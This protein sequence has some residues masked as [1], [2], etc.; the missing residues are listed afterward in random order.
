VTSPAGPSAAPPGL[1]DRLRF[2][3][4]KIPAA[5]DRVEP[6]QWTDLLLDDRPEVGDSISGMLLRVGI[7]ARLLHADPTGT[8]DEVQRRLA[9]GDDRHAVMDAL[10]AELAP[11]FD[12]A[13]DTCVELVR[14]GGVIA[15]PDLER[16][17]HARL[18]LDPADPITDA[19]LRDALERLLLDPLSEV[20]GVP[21]GAVVH[22][23]TLLRGCV[24][25][26][27]P[28]ETETAEGR[29]LLDPDLAVFGLLGEPRVAAGPLAPELDDDGFLRWT[30][31]AGWLP[32]PA[33]GDVLTVR[34]A[35]GTVEIGTAPGA[36]PEPPE[37]VSALR[38]VYDGQIAAP[39]L[40]LTG[41]LLALGLLA[42]DPAAFAQPVAPLAELAAAAGL[43]QR[44]REFGHAEEAWIA[45]AQLARADRLARR[46][47]DEHV[48]RAEAALDL[49]AA[50]AP[51]D[52][53]LRTVLSL[54]DDAD[55]LLA[56]ADELIGADG[57]EAQV[58]AAVELGDRFVAA[59]GS[60]ARAAAAHAFASLA[61]ERAGRLDDA[62]SHLRAAAAVSEWWLVDERLGWYASDRGRAAEALGHLRDAGLSEIHEPVAVL[63]PYAVPV[64]VPAR[65]EPCW[66][67]SGRKYK[68]C[69][70]DQPPLP[71]LAERVPWLE[72]KTVLYLDRRGGAVDVLI[73]GLA[74]VLAGGDGDPESVLDDP[75][76]ADVALVEGGWLARFVAERGPLLPPDEAE[77]AAAW[78]AV[79]RKVYEIVGIGYGTG[80]TVRELG[81]G[82]DGFRV[83]DQEVAKAA[84]A[85]ELIC[86]RAVDD[87]AGGLRFSGVVTA[88]PR[89]REDELREVLDTGNPYAVL[90]WL[91]EAEYLG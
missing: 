44:G 73:D 86:A 46:L 51:T 27:N 41:D 50:G 54:L 3:F 17:V 70:R 91:A 80:V 38:A 23:P 88:V 89:G 2:L 64:A 55:V 48:E 14:A 6:G 69:H 10:V 1:D 29:L 26:H 74:D 71:L 82:G 62:E 22:V 87:G 77:L 18:A 25:T 33:A 78:A 39:P 13:Y 35:D 21:S 40:P 79:P 42:A 49:V 59:A 7:A 75:L 63:T 56:V 11:L 28:S 19:V 83:G 61:V 72:Q 36:L 16:E 5:A 58:A 24:L 60:S 37:L 45:A 4:G 30:G 65:N 81:A 53:D 15:G 66:C 34:T 67:G 68:H 47:D 90:D 32:R 8:W 84:T 57:D 12:A 31:P 52:A 43:Q 85:G 9:A 76:L 20:A